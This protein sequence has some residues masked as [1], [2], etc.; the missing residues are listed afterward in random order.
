[1]N[2]LAFLFA[3]LL[4]LTGCELEPTP[5][6][7][8]FAVLMFALALIGG[9]VVFIVCNCGEPL[10]PPNLTKHYDPDC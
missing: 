5:Q 6:T 9:W 8:C 10:P 7:G 4:M 2:R 3:G 1:M